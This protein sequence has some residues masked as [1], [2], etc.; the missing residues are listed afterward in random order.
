MVR[1]AAVCLSFNSSLVGVFPEVLASASFLLLR[2]VEWSR[3]PSRLHPPPLHPS[4]PLSLSSSG[5]TRSSAG[6]WCWPEADHDII[7]LVCGSQSNPRLTRLCTA[8][9]TSRSEFRAARRLVSIRRFIP[10]TQPNGMLALRR[11]LVATEGNL[12]LIRS[13]VFLHVQWGL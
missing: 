5:L 7:S 2:V 10:V 3:A 8:D 6:R 1:R 11:H 12:L 13:G 9:E 4:F